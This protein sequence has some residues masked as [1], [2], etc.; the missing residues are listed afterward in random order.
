MKTVLQIV[1]VGW[2]LLPWDD[3]NVGHWVL[4]GAAVIIDGLVGCALLLRR[5]RARELAR[6]EA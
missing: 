4:L 6:R 1:M 2:W 5:H 3:I